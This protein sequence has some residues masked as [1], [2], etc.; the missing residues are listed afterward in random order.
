M[1]ILLSRK[2][3][4]ASLLHPST[5]PMFHTSSNPPSFYTT[6]PKYLNLEV[7]IQMILYVENYS[8]TNL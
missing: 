1:D 3:P 5:N 4:D 6:D 2:I 8:K 7:L